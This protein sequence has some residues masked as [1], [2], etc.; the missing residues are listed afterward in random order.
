MDEIFVSK[1]RELYKSRTSKE[2]QAERRHRM[3]EEQRQQRSKAVDE[4][5]GIMAYIQKHP[6]KTEGRS[7]DT[8]PVFDRFYANKV[9]LSE[10]LRERPEDLDN[11]YVVPCPK[12]KRCLVV[13]NDRTIMYSKAGKILSTF[14]SSLEGGKYVTVL[15]CIYAGRKREFH[16]LDCLVY[17]NQEFIH[18]ETAFRFF[19]LTS[20]FLEYDYSVVHR[21]NH[22]P[23]HYIPRFDCADEASLASA[24]GTHPHWPEDSPTLD[25][26]LFYHKEASY[27]YGTTPLVGWLFSYMIPEVLGISALHADYLK[28]P[29]DYTNALE[30]MEAFDRK[31]RAKNQRGRR[32][33][34]MEVEEDKEDDDSA[35][36]EEQRLLETGELD[37]DHESL[38]D[39]ETK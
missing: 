30:F 33:S 3:L 18:C 38:E 6:R 5:R 8:V 14:R 25:G 28:P 27:T 37:M 22:Y 1:Y 34:K 7:R 15:D 16:V 10:W 32:S 24:F 26:F 13:A 12:G 29:D 11:W 20:K 35:V 23:F 19:W 4:H 21:D 17:R 9:Q 36:L 31:Q 39:Q 2:S